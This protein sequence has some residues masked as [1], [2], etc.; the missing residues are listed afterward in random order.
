MDRQTSLVNAFVAWLVN[1][2]STI[3]LLRK[4]VTTWK[5]CYSSNTTTILFYYLTPPYLKTKFI[6]SIFEVRLMYLHE[7]C[8]YCIGAIP[9]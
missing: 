6:V 4:A 3:N 2:S 7:E 5:S 9:I 1:S 8:K